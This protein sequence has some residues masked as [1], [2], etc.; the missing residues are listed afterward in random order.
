MAKPK[1]KLTRDEIVDFR[2][3]TDFIRDEYEAHGI[4]PSW[5][6][7]MAQVKNMTK[8]YDITY[9][10][11][12]NVLKYMTQIEDVDITSYDTLGLVPYY[13]DRTS[14]YIEKYK[15]VKKSINDFNFEEEVEF[16]K[17]IKQNRRRE[18]KNE[19]F[20]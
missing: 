10:G 13:I 9:I 15:A 16:I 1:N 6:L 20:E 4:E 11:I 7:L 12:L 8:N 17:P 19:T 2:K 18:R 3:L 14:R 5:N